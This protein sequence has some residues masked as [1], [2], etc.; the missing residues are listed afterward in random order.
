MKLALI[1]GVLTCSGGAIGAL[2]LHGRLLVLG[3]RSV[4]ADGARRTTPMTREITLAP[5][6]AYDLLP[7]YVDLNVGDTLRVARA[8]GT[9]VA[10]RIA[11]IHI[12]DASVRSPRTR[13]DLDVDGRTIAAHCGMRS[14]N[15]GGIGA[16]EIDGVRVGVEVTHLLFSSI[17]GGKSPFNQYRNLQLRG[18]VRLAAWDAAEHIIRG[19]EGVFVID[20]PAW[21]R[22]EYGNW[23]H[24]TSYG[25]H[26]GID[27]YATHSGAR[28]PVRCPVDGVVYRVY[29]TD[30]A[31]DDPTRSKA[32]NIYSEA[33]VGPNGEHILFRMQHLSEILVTGGQ[34]VQAGQVVGFTGHTGFDA[35]I[36][37][38]LHF[39]IRLNPSHF[40]LAPNG[41]IFSSVPVNPYF[42]LQEWYARGDNHARH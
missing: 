34:A 28:E 7:H 13:V 21:I 17:K 42:Y 24:R 41:D 30:A 3:P 33:V 36:G 29:N 31:A 32:I 8:D 2:L 4:T 27:V 9:T 11:G 23:L 25:L 18:D 39:E 5:Q 1:V 38:H 15:S 16:I 22:N 37:D 35:S 6:H 10:I 12:E 40:G 19:V 14:A 20:Q 26:G